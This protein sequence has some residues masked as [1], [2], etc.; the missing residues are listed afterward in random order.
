M[1]SIFLTIT[2]DVRTLAR[3]WTLQIGQPAQDGVKESYCRQN[4]FFL[5]IMILVEATVEVAYT[6][7]SI[8]QHIGLDAP[9]LLCSQ[10]VVPRAS[11][12]IASKTES[13]T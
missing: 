13:V 4:N 8:H 10:S 9:V 2:Y 3:Q 1:I 12:D 5:D 7:D 11:A 6:S